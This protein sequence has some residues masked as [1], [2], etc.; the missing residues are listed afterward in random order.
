MDKATIAREV[1]D[2]AERLHLTEL[3]DRKPQALSGGQRQR[4]A[5]GRAIIKKP[6]VILFDE[7]LSNLDAALRVQ[8]RAE[9]QQLHQ[10]TQS[11]IIYVT[12]DQVEA[13]TLADRIV[14]LKD[15]QVF[16]ADHPIEL[17]KAPANTFVAQFIGSPRMNLIPAE[18]VASDATGVKL[19]TEAGWAIVM[20][21]RAGLSTG[22]KVTLGIRPES[23]SLAAPGADGDIVAKVRVAERLGMETYISLETGPADDDLI[24]RVTGDHIMR[25]GAEARFDVDFAAAHLFDTSGKAIR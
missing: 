1:G 4:V 22:D 2:V 11:T 13:M 18:I 5:I 19:R 15:G 9:L 23:L 8:M 25:S 16:Q 20:P 10:S 3:L 17:Y 6:K 21:P 14:V 12:H 7:P 24:A